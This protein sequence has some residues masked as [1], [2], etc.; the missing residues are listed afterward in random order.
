MLFIQWRIRYSYSSGLKKFGALQ[1]SKASNNWA[2]IV[3]QWGLKIVN[4]MTETD[5]ASARDLKGKRE[6]ASKVQLELKE[7]QRVRKKIS[8]ALAFYNLLNMEMISLS[9]SEPNYFTR[10]E[11]DS[12]EV[13]VST[14]KS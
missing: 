8:P 6:G 11:N 10:R 5:E 3:A 12:I 1:V 13:S 2:I 9:S 4:S 14:L 7:A